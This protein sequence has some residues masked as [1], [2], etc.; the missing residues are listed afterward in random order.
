LAKK[1]KV[2]RDPVHGLITFDKEKEGV[3]VDLID[4]P[5]FQR[6]RRIRQLGV[7]YVAF[8]GAEH[9]RFSHS[10]GVCH[11]AGKY[12]D[13]LYEIDEVGLFK[14]NDDFEARRLLVRCA[15][16]LHDIGHGP[17]SHVFESS[18]KKID[19]AYNTS[20][21][22]WTR[23]ILTFDKG[24]IY[25]VLHNYGIDP[26]II[27]K[28]INRTYE[29]TLL[30]NIVTSQFDADRMDYLQRDSLF[31]GVNYGNID[32]D[33]LIYSLRP[34]ITHDGQEVL[35]VDSTKGKNSIVDYLL[36]RKNLFEQLYFHHKIRAAEIQLSNI[37]KR[38]GF[39]IKNGKDFLQ[40]ESLTNLFAN[41]GDKIQ[42]DDYLKTNDFLIFTVMMDLTNYKDDYT[43]QYLCKDFL[44]NRI[45]KSEPMIMNTKSI[46][47]EAKL[48]GQ[49]KNTDLISEFEYFFGIDEAR[50][51]YYENDYTRGGEQ[52]GEK[53]AR[54]EVW[55]MNK[56]N[57]EEISYVSPE[58]RAIMHSPENKTGKFSIC[59][60]GNQFDRSKV[61]S[62]IN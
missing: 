44:S 36:A 57:L 7:A 15:A 2:F 45:F 29:D 24:S 31:A 35:S 1:S 21:E 5:E 20:H 43:L 42:I 26:N 4:T 39:L 6:L 41:V 49:F 13:R 23:N 47:L 51:T 56:G 18:M 34:G 54:N 32:Q 58:I 19:I 27:Q 16:L 3:L 37:F 53:E 33:W 9:S 59:F 50:K 55:V 22:D 14:E 38:I 28:I 62:L 30:V 17:F 60:D 25:Q 10:I 40:N 11:L 52:E 12:M 8:H 46:N 48:K 61:K